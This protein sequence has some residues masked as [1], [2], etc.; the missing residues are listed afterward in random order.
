M[1]LKIFLST[2]IEQFSEA[3]ND[4]KDGFECYFIKGLCFSKLCSVRLAI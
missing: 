4:K 1:D 2:P 3:L